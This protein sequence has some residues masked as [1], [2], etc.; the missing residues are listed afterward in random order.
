MGMGMR[1]R[2]GTGTRMGMGMEIIKPLSEYTELP[3]SIE[4]SASVIKDIVKRMSP[5]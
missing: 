4:T 2:M 3:V 1:T 5:Q